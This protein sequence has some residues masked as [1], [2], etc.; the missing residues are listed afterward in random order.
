LGHSPLGDLAKL[1]LIGH[2]QIPLRSPSSART[3]MVAKDLHTSVIAEGV[4]TED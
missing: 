2:H 3:M 1:A 4:E